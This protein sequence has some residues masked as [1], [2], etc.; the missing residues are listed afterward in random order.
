M[1]WW[2]VPR[3]CRHYALVLGGVRIKWFRQWRYY[4]CNDCQ[5]LVKIDS[6]TGEITSA[7]N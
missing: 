5:E 6:R 7:A 1:I 2:P 3:K 4:R